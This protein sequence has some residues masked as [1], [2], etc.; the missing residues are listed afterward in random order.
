MLNSAFLITN[1]RVATDSLGTNLSCV[2]F[3]DLFWNSF[4]RSH[5]LI[6]YK[7]LCLIFMF[8]NLS[9]SSKVSPIISFSAARNFFGKTR[10]VQFLLRFGLILLIVSQQLV[11]IWVMFW[12]GINRF[13]VFNEL[14]FPETSSNISLLEFKWACTSRKVT[15]S[16]WCKVLIWCLR[17][18]AALGCWFRQRFWY[19]GSPFWY[20][21]WLF[22]L[23]TCF[24]FEIFF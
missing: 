17:F 24:L 23:K 8:K 22:I 7:I 2:H 14:V 9:I 19:N 10:S 6:I 15:E 1:V 4:F 20:R 16:L 12:N 13:F 5:K 18:L 21:F 11:L 3:L